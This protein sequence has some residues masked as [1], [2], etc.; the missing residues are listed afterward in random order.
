MKQIWN[1]YP[2]IKINVFNYNKVLSLIN[3]E[4]GKKLIFFSHP[5]RCLMHGV[6]NEEKY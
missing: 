1:K 3:S 5:V 4:K 6:F 2:N